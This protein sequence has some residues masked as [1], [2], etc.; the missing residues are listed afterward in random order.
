MRTLLARSDTQTALHAL[1]LPAEQITQAVHQ[2]VQAI[3]EGSTSTTAGDGG[4]TGGGVKY[5]G[6]AV[7]DDEGVLKGAVEK[8]ILLQHQGQPQNQEYLI[9]GVGNGANAIKVRVRM[10]DALCSDSITTNFSTASVNQVCLPGL[11]GHYCFWVI[12]AVQL[13][14]WTEGVKPSVQG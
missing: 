4:G 10:Q 9:E 12:T 13:H 11:A 14:S 3:M 7:G 8:M 6:V 1:Q 2:A 5:I